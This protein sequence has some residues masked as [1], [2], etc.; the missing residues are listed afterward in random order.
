MATLVQDLRYG[1]RLLAKNPGFTA[2]AVLT[3]ALGIGA[4]T[5][6]F[7]VINGLFLHPKGIQDPTHLFAIRVRYTKLNLKSI[8][9]SAPD[10]ADVRDSRQVFS[11]TAASDEEGFNYLARD[12]PERLMAAKV[13]WEWFNVF[14]VRPLA[15]RVFRPEEDQ[16]HSNQV[17]V[18]AYHTWRRLFGG[19]P[20]IVGKSIQLN[21]VDYRVVGIMGSDFEWPRRADLWVPLGLAPSELSRDNYYNECCFVVARARP[22][23]SPDQAEAFVQVLT[24]RLIATSPQGN[25]PKDSGWGIFAIPFTEY[26]AGDMRTPMLIL[27]GAVGFVLL[28]AC[29]N[30]GGLILARTSARTREF[31]IRVALGAARR[32]LLRQALT[33]SFLLT[34]IGAAL[35]IA[36]SYAG[37]GNLLKLA[38]GRL[39]SRLVVG[40]DGH[41]LLF[42]VALSVLTG[43]FLG[44]VPIT[45]I[46][47]REQSEVLKEEA[48]SVTAGQ[49]RQR[50]RESLVIGQ[51]ALALVLLVGAGLLLKSLTRMAQVDPGFDPTGVMTASVQL[52]ENQ[53]ASD[54]KRAA[55]YR[56]VD[57]K[58]AALPG[59]SSAASAVALPFTGFTPSSS[60][61]IE[62]R[63]LGPGDPGPHSN[64][65]WVSPEYFQALRIP[66]LKGRYFTGQDRLGTQPV[67]VIDD[68]LARQ[69]WPNQ[70]P[71]GRR[72]RRGNNAPWHTI[73]GVVGH[74]MQSALVGDSGKGVCF[75]P[76][77]QQPIEQ[78]FLIAKTKTDPVSM[79]NSI[80]TAVASVDPGQ[81][82][83]GLETMEQYVATSLGPQR[84]A[85]SLLGFFSVVALLLACLGLYGVISYNVA[86]RT[87]EIGIR[88]A[89]GAQREQVWRL[90]L[91]QGMRLALVGILAGACAASF[92]VHYLRSELF[93]VSAFDPVTFALTS[94]VLLAVALL[95]CHIPAWRA[96]RVDPMVALRY[97]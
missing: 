73:V 28:I 47:G 72:L 76:I 15:G 68:N 6:T 10:F 13:T 81:P 43:I 95:A 70:D 23:I 84:I 52:P 86:Q 97:E 54:E 24:Q 30:I 12:G 63:P 32:D 21:H 71:I 37:L 38:P 94:L 74:T 78:A 79:G 69:Y 58:L 46:F 96:T 4:N 1:S 57:E 8:V 55:F 9:I 51:V 48:R 92:V 82:V 53:Y 44:V 67:V 11:C 89:L 14:G 42:T 77:L 62:D 33:E 35:G 65:N 40:I 45:Q 22:E 7:S 60:F 85:A 39:S 80:R 29:S 75:Y 59:V 93:E 25:Y 27:L 56:A 83:A 49:G 41:V 16:P 17:A 5:V 18:L 88:M 34:A 31:A 36:A 61:N 19:D 91:A 2:V 64:L 90:V 66:L 87:H 50:L 3:L 26:T 20:A